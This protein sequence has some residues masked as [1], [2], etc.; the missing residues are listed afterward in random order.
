MLRRAVGLLVV[1]VVASCQASGGQSPANSGATTPGT[2]A[3][4]SDVSTTRA[5]VDLRVAS[6]IVRPGTEALAT[7]TP[8]SVG[9]PSQVSITVPAAL[10][11]RLGAFGDA[12]GVLLAP[13]GG[14]CTDAPTDDA[15]MLVTSTDGQG[16]IALRVARNDATFA[17]LQ[18][19]PV[20]AS[21]QRQWELTGADCL[22]PS[23]GEVD[24]AITSELV[25]FT[26]PP[27]VVGSGWRSGNAFESDG[28]VWYHVDGEQTQAATISC[29]VS[30]AEHDLCDPILSYFQSALPASPAGA[31][32]AELASFGP[33]APPTA[34]PTAPPMGDCAI[35][36]TDA[37]ATVVVRGA[38]MG[39]CTSAKHA[40]LS[41]GVF[42]TVNQAAMS[43]RLR[44]ICEGPVV[45]L[46]SQ[47]EVWDLG[48]ATYAT[49]ICQ[50][51][52]LV[53]P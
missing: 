14:T 11:D 44:L 3:S 25:A 24:R 1:L 46:S 52:N 19:C 15:V 50:G 12:H 43:K 49:M 33:T 20:F 53:S 36:L 13:V 23:S 18:A 41:I 34:S 21:A 4:G 26:D 22:P 39:A 7:S 27:Q 28:L 9:T 37:S 6:C 10:K 38:G 42:Y 32:P 35:Q 16:E 30:P 29:T 45:G 48:G 47:V 51:W 40:L 17:S 2:G 5:T 31:P 8:A